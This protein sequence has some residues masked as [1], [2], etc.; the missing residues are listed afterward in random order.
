MTI[1]DEGYDYSVYNIAVDERG[2][3]VDL[4]GVT[5]VHDG[6]KSFYKF[7]H[8]SSVYPEDM[9]TYLEFLQSYNYMSIKRFES[10]S[11][12]IS[13]NPLVNMKLAILNRTSQL[14]EK[15]YDDHVIIEG[16]NYIAKYAHY[17]DVKNG[18]EKVVYLGMSKFSELTLSDLASRGFIP[19]AN[20][21]LINRIDNIGRGTT[22]I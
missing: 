10:K 11:D 21:P 19:I 14:I 9:K 18:E 22:R 15:V 4:Y 16:I 17:I 8:D 3:R 12:V 13:T 1:K 5:L 2:L 6:K 20:S 7:D